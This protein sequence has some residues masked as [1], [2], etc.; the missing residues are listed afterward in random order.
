MLPPAWAGQRTTGSLRAGPSGSTCTVKRSVPGGAPEPAWSVRT[1]TEQRNATGP[2]RADHSAPAEAW[3]RD[4]WGGGSGRVRRRHWVGQPPP[5]PA[6]RPMP[7]PSRR[8]STSDTVATSLTTSSSPGLDHGVTW[9][10]HQTATLRGRS[11]RSR[12]RANLKSWK[13][14]GRSWASSH[15]GCTPPPDRRHRPAQPAGVPVAE[16][17]R[18]FA[19][20]EARGRSPRYERFA[21]GVAGDRQLVALLDRLPR[22]S[23]NPIC[24]SRPCCT[25]CPPTR[26]R[27]LPRLR[28]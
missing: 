25:G 6:G 10:T 1:W 26:L 5:L 21:L 14:C 13:G 16:R 17:Y 22:P 3:R 12:R 20:R 9:Q 4:V 11:P 2:G 18:R 19:E 23:S 28:T 7:H 15:G 8:S 24:C 27:R